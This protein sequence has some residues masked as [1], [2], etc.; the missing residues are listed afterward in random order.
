M[1]RGI[2]RRNSLE[3]RLESSTRREKRSK[4]YRRL[5]REL[6][7]RKFTKQEL[8]RDLRTTSHDTSP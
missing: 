7:K 6:H 3:I 2:T 5:Q 8:R 1:K 4:S